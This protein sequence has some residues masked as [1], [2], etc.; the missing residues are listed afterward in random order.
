MGKP[1]FPI[2]PPGGRVWEG[3]ARKQGDGE[4]GFP[5]P[6]ASGRV[7]EGCALPGTTFS[8]GV[9]QGDGEARFPHPRETF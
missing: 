5:I 9:E 3:Y 7:R 6:S 2:P 8:A 1:G 4:S